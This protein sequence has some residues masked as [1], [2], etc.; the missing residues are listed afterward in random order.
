MRNCFYHIINIQNEKVKNLY[1]K[2]CYLWYDEWK[3]K[4]IEIVKYGYKQVSVRKIIVNCF[5][6]VFIKFVFY[7]IYWIAQ[8]L[9]SW[10]KCYNLLVQNENG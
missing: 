9:I 3:K 5:S 8:K 2:I 6:K 10:R 1:A 7:Y 4:K